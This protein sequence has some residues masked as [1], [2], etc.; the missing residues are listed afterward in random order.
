MDPTTGYSDPGAL[1]GMVA[2]Y[3]TYAFVMLIFAVIM[4]IAYWKVFTKAGEAG[5]QSIIPIWNVIVVLKIA[6]RPWWWILLMLIPLVQVVVLFIVYLDIA[7]SFGHGI[8]FALGL[9]FLAPIFWLIL[10]FGSSRYVGAGGVAP[11]PPM[12]AY[13][14]PAAAAAAVPA[15]APPPPVAA[16]PAPAPAAAPPAPAP[17]PP[18]Q[19]AP[20]PAAV[21][22]AP[23]APAM[24][25]PAAP[26]V[27]AAPP[28]PTAEPPAAESGGT[29]RT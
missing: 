11:A 8:G 2:F 16:P 15:A 7:K 22:P 6:G 29:G 3:T 24:E 26:P 27:E 9:F 21:P 23:E 10:G 18:M 4:I 13:A 1:A 19:A 5:W 25:A 20:A 12:P 17:A 28:A 14:A